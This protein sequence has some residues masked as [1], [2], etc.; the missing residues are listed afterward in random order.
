MKTKSIHISDVRPGDTVI[1]GG[2]LRTVCASDIRRSEFMGLTLFGDCYQ[3]G[4][5]PVVLA[6]DI[7]GRGAS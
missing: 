6:I 2:T 4:H 3:L 7:S 5:K 1:H